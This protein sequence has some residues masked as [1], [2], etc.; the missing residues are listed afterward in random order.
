MVY[1][2]EY[3][4]GPD[5]LCRKT[6]LDENFKKKNVPAPGAYN[7]DGKVQTSK[8]FKYLNKTKN[9]FIEQI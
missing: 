6:H 1:H 3:N 2:K 4:S 9:T 5:H 8:K 7:V